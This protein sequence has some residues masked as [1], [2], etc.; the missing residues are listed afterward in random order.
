MSFLKS[1]G[2]AM[3][4]GTSIVTGLAP[5]IAP[6]ANIIAP[7]SGAAITVVTDT[8][9]AIIEKIC[10][11]ETIGQQMGAPGAKKLELATPLV[12]QV[13][14]ASPLLRDKK[15]IDQAKF[16]GA[17]KGLSSNMADL[18]NSLEAVNTAPRP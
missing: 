10:L 12:A 17:V 7:G 3:L 6:V 1:F 5:M 15:V 4:R 13:I 16:D 9:V 8:F 18:L 14:L 11:V 2:E